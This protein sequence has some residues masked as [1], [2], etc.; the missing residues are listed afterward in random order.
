MSDMSV[1]HSRDG[2]AHFAR[3]N[4]SGEGLPGNFR[5]YIF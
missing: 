2:S 5:D 3:C 4:E 1:G